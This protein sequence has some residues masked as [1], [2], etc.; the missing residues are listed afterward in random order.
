MLE[1]E[2]LFSCHLLYLNLAKKNHFTLFKFSN[3]EWQDGRFKR[4]CFAMGCANVV[5]I[6][7]MVPEFQDNLW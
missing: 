5:G 3:E 1:K 2:D 4:E 7:G 6:I